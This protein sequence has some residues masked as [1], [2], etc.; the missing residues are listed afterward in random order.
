LIENF[1]TWQGEG[2]DAG[3]RMIIL[4]FKT[5]NLNCPWCDTSVKMRINAEANYPLSEIQKQIN[6]NYAGILVTGGEPTVDRHFNETVHLLNDLKY[7]LANVETNGYNLYELIQTIHPSKKVKY[8][9]SPKLYDANNT[10]MAREIS[11]KVIGHHLVYFKLVCD[12]SERL[13]P[14]LEF[15]LSLDKDLRW[16]GRICLMPEGTM[17]E[18]LIKNSYHV[19]DLCEKYNVNFSSRDHII[20]GFI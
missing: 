1:V 4:R 11:E 8:I 7:P 10:A 17:R 2:T 12:G 5:C 18:D 20:Y 16:N 15:L 19:F 3:R 14:F 13:E 6:D 9:F